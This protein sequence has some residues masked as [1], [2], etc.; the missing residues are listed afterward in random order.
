MLD[1][2][3]H[4]GPHMGGVVNSVFFGL[5]GVGLRLRTQQVDARHIYHHRDGR[6]AAEQP[7]R[8]Q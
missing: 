1:A 7:T 5:L 4:T 8:P 6:I 3:R 2:V